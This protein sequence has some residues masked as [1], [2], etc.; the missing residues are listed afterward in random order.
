M[1]M[2]R[3]ADTLEDTTVASRAFRGLR[4]L[5]GIV[6]VFLSTGPAVAE[7]HAPSG[8]AERLRFEHL[9]T[10]DGLSH[11]TVMAVAQDSHGFMWFGTW[12]GLN[13]YD[14]YEVI[15][16]KHDSADPQSLGGNTVN[17]LLTDREGVLWIATS[18]G[19]SRFDRQTETF[20]TYRH[21]PADPQSLGHNEVWTILESSD[22][23]LWAL[24]LGGGLNKLD[25][26]TGRFTRFL[27]DPGNPRSLSSD[28]GRALHEDRQ[29]FLWVGTPKDGLNQLDRQTGLVTRYL[30][31]PADPH[32]LSGND[33]WSIYEDSRGDL[34]VGTR[35]QGLNRLDRETGRFRRYAADRDSPTSLAGGFVFDMHEDRSG[36]LWIGTFDGG[37]HRYDREEDHFLRY[38]PDPDDPDSL[39]HFQVTAIHEDATGALWI[40]TFGSGVDRLDRDALKFRVYE[41]VPDDPNS[42]GG[43]DVRAVHEDASGI[44]WIGTYDGGLTRF[45]RDRWELTHY[46]HDPA[47]PQSLSDN[48][49]QTLLEDT[50][51]RIWL[52]TWGGGL[53]QLDRRTGKFTRYR[54]DPD[55]PDSLS[56]DDVRALYEGPEGFLWI[57]TSS[58]GLNRLDPETE[59]FSHYLPEPDNPKGIND[60]V[61][62]TMQGDPAGLLWL[63]IWGGGLN[64][65]EI[66]TATVTRYEADP[67][68][69][70]SLSSNEVWAIHQG[71]SGDFWLGTSAGLNRFDPRTEDF[72][73]YRERDGLASDAVYDVLEDDR[74]HLW[75]ITG[76][77]VTRFDPQAR[78]FKNYDEADGVQGG[79]NFIDGC[80]FRSSDRE[81]FIGG[82]EGLN[83]F[84]PQE[85]TENAY[86][87]PIAL[88]GF[89]I[90]NKPVPIGVPESPLKKSITE[91]EHLTLGY[92]DS[93]FTLSFAAL[94]YRAPHKNRYAYKLD[95]LEEDWNYVDGRRRYATY[96]NLDPGSYTFRVR[97]SNND[98]LWSETERSLQIRVL[99]PFWETRWFRALAVMAL[100]G[101]VWGTF[102]LRTARM[103]ARNLALQAEI[104]ERKRV[105]REREDL[106]TELGSKNE[107]LEAQKA[108]LERFVYTA[109]HD[110]KTPLVTI[111][112]FLGLLE[113]D[114]AAGNTADLSRHVAVIGDA[115]NK[116]RRLLDE[117]IELSR[118]GR[119][120][121][122]DEWVPLDELA[123]Q[124]VELVS[125]PIRARG[126]EVVV[127][128]EM[129]RVWGDRPRLLEVMQILVDNAVK[130]MGDQPTPRVEV[131]ACR[132]GREVLCHVR[133]NGIGIDPKYHEKVFSLFDRL[134]P[135]ID[136][137]G[138]GLALAKRI[139]EVHG[140]RIWAESDGE[141]QG[142]TFFFTL[143]LDLRLD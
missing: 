89:Q 87:P 74:G 76:V 24:T 114:A 97:G 33:V 71:T 57:A 67:G 63:G 59:S 123:R 86:P 23:V 69:P 20:T 62:F 56:N 84:D 5:A 36:A 88:T 51:G 70:A 17:A 90:F 94:S 73:A 81:L 127:E 64:K 72:T 44:F 120:I 66:E 50:E 100:A 108:E 75:L 25:R 107:Q 104:Q 79:A 111:T 38:G 95:G 42:L 98:G 49:I 129:P 142:T 48:R 78:Q 133:D 116:M 138:A 28:N 102:L 101:V 2:P 15:E 130:F 8:G 58:G 121:N 31:D 43:K 135:S 6:A 112:G 45:D 109:S 68:N 106:I 61:I 99:P 21:D 125:E 4:A 113:R 54:H 12:G 46:R 40:G 22:G 37:L 82:K 7:R 35:T 124:A 118:I 122:A 83:Y 91:T 140:G 14:G 60:G 131:G 27:H 132:Q 3:F 141:G 13:R 80:I 9:T 41:H 117:L 136:G 110:L 55:V 119:I 128:E 85:I 143:P 18:T 10:D 29:G 19:L 65:F 77:G 32:S 34:W 139:V 105:E 137:S 30:H 11:G 103:R 16:Y 47:D 92:R 134:N 26:E 115:S 96:T 52:G 39:S 1:L 126:V 93:V 53:N